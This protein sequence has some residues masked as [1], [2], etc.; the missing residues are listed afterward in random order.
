M[1]FAVEVCP[2]S[3]IRAVVFDCDGVLFDSALANIRFFDAALASAG[4]DRLDARG[5]QLALSLS[6][7]QL[8]EEV[9]ADEYERVR[10][11]AAAVA[12][13]YGPFYDFMQPVTG[14]HDLLTYLRRHY[15]I[16]M[17]TNR[18]RTIHEVIRRFD[19]AP[20]LEVALGV[21][22]VE[23]PK[24]DPEML[25]KCLVQLDTEPA[26]AVYVG[27]QDTDRRAAEAAGM[28]FVAVG[29]ETEAALRIGALAEL[30]AVLARL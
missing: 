5:R 21:L 29:D 11:L 14:L 27:D 7:H 26:H 28:Y 23:R 30:P 15:R 16:G 12:L 1:S 25:T 3:R 2:N 13:D 20:Y 22:D 24:P 19:L 4:L 9:C 6:T 10:L 8:V 17:A 18:G